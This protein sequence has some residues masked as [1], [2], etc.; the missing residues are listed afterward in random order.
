MLSLK[1]LA[2]N[3]VALVAPFTRYMHLGFCVLCVRDASPFVAIR[4]GHLRTSLVAS[5]RL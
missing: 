5:G 2:I 4:L 3:D 1:L